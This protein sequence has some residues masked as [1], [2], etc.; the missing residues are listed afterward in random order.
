[1][2][3]HLGTPVARPYSRPSPGTLTPLIVGLGRVLFLCRPNAAPSEDAWPDSRRGPAVLCASRC[4]GSAF[5]HPARPCWIARQ[6]AAED[7]LD[8]RVCLYDLMRGVAGFTVHVVE[9]ES[10]FMP[11]L[12]MQGWSIS[13][14]LSFNGTSGPPP[15]GAL[16]TTKGG[17]IISIVISITSS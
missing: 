17:W 4:A 12:P 9:P 8:G 13:T 10:G 14:G 6:I 1:V 16:F 5:K 7:R 3:Q 15:T 11:R 2:D